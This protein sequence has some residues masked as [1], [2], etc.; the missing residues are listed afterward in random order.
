MRRLLTAILTAALLLSLLC[1]CGAAPAKETGKLRIVA[2]IFPLYDWT[3][4]LLGEQADGIDLTLL[5]DDGVDLHSFQPSVSDMISV[6]SCDLLIYVGGESD[7]WIADAIA[8]RTN[9]DMIAL[10]LMEVLG[11]RALQEELVEGMQ[12]EAE[13]TP[14]EHIWLSLRNAELLCAAIRDALITLD[15]EHSRGYEAAFA[16]YDAKLR[17]LDAAYT[18]VI[19]ASEHRTLIV[20]DRFPFRYLTEDYGLDY[21]AAFSGCEAETEASFATVI[22]LAGKADELG[23]KQLCVIETSDGKLARTVIENTKSRDLGVLTLHSMQG[24]VGEA[25][26]LSLMEQNL[27]VLKE[28]LN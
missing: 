5:L 14:D 11:G 12:G 15:A 8:E 24:A 13:D 21:Y 28:A 9:P 25:D 27:N 23:V 3:K 17:K 2:T 6:S 26:Y 20:A 19:D 1:G 22:F 4:N 10:N 16:A 18:A 7:A